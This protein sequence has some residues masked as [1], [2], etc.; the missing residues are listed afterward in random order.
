ML[1]IFRNQPNSCL[2]I[3]FRDSAFFDKGENACIKIPFT[4]NPKP[5]IT[6]TR[7]GENVETGAHFQVWNKSDYPFFRQVLSLLTF[8]QVKTE[9]RHALLTIMDCSKVDSGPYTITASNELGQDFA[10]INVQVRKDHSLNVHSDFVHG[11]MD[12]DLR[13]LKGG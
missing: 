4:G 11:H 1:Q 5:R 10:I 9:E 13:G 3:R 7:E 12:S 2:S 6:W 8:L